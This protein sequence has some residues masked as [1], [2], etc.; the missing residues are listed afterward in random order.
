M[1]D[2]IIK[3]LYAEN[4]RVTRAAMFVYNVTLVTLKQDINIHNLGQRVLLN[5]Q[6]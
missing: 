5:D 1:T 2:T 4:I 3:F 6:K